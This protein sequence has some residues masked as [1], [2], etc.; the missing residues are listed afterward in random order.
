[1]SPSELAMKELEKKRMVGGLMSKLLG[2]GAVG[3]H[4]EKE[5]LADNVQQIVALGDDFLE[6]RFK[7]GRL[8]LSAEELALIEERC[9]VCDGTGHRH[10]PW[11]HWRINWL[12]NLI[13]PRK[14]WW[15]EGK[16]TMPKEI[17]S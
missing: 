1:M 5:A 16:G 7:A 2:Q 11:L 15:C 3:P 12:I 8:N 9:H 4:P 10:T 17:G 13:F 6:V 14:C